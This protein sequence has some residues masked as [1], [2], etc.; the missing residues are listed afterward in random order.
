MIRNEDKQNKKIDVKTL[1]L[2]HFTSYYVHDFE[3]W[4]A[5]IQTYRHTYRQT[6]KEKR[7]VHYL[8]VVVVVVVVFLMILNA[9]FMYISHIVTAMENIVIYPSSMPPQA[10]SA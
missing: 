2:F 3:C 9:L 6:N 8:F 10:N 4:L 7:C 5:D 1:D